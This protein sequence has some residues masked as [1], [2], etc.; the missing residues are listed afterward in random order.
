[1]V[2]KTLEPKKYFCSQLPVYIHATF[3]DY[4]L[5]MSFFSTPNQPL[6]SL[7]TTL[8]FVNSACCLF[9]H[10]NELGRTFGG[11][12]VHFKIL[13]IHCAETAK[14]LNWK[15][16]YYSYSTIAALGS[17]LFTIILVLCTSRLLTSPLTCIFHKLRRHSE[18][19]NGSDINTIKPLWHAPYVSSQWL[20]VQMGLC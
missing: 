9:S 1:M 17:T 4:Y 6:L 16:V 20:M 8:L 5:D 2:I 10:V 13:L 18:R 7:S 11:F 3:L 14:I 15:K 19:I 12:A